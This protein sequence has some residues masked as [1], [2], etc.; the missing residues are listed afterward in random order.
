M[1]LLALPTSFGIGNFQITFYS[2]FI[3][4]GAIIALLIGMYR[5]KLL[6]YQPSRL[7]NLFLVAFPAG[8]IGARLW[9]IICQWNEFAPAFEINFWKG[10]GGLFG[11]TDTGIHIAGLAIEGGAFLGIVAGVLFVIFRRKEMKALDVA[12]VVIP[13]I[14]LA[15]AIGRW[16][17]FFNQEVYGLAVDPA[18]WAWLGSWFTNQMTVNGAFR[19]PLFLIESLLNILGFLVLS[20]ITYNKWIKKHIAPGTAAAGYFIWYGTVRAIL[21]PMRDPL[22]IMNDYISVTTSIVFIVFGVLCLIFFNLYRYYLKKKFKLHLFDRRV[23]PNLYEDYATGEYL[24]GD[25]NVVPA[26]EVKI[27]KYGDA[28]KEKVEEVKAQEQEPIVSERVEA[29][30]IEPEVKEEAVKKTATKK[31][32]TAKKTSS[33]EK[34]ATTTKKTT[35]TKKSSSK[36]ATKKVEENGK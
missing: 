7:E 9:Y 28:S 17:N 1:N 11:I 13:G 8:L 27:D 3:L 6:G 35:T 30:V 12:D 4:T 34:K 16:G 29:P 20:F 23:G 32:T 15:Q 25:Y 24:D 2:I 31:T 19:Q 26:S 5:I 33:N 14:L 21:E 18:P 10:L 36:K 22:F